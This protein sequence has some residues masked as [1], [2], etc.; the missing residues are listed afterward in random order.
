MASTSDPSFLGTGWS[1]PP[2]FSREVLGVETVS[3]LADIRESLQILFSTAQ[4]ERIMLPDYGCD[5][6]RMVFHDLTTTLTTRLRDMVE[7]AIVLWEPRIDVLS[8]TADADPERDGL[9]NIGVEFTVRRTNTRSNFV[10]P[11]MLGEA[12]LVRPES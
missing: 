6:W 9:V 8:V 7:Q 2:T 11:F 12:T 4:G 10:Y 5:L 3:G 1:F